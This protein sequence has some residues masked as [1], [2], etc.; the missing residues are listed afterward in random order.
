MGPVLKSVGI[1]SPTKQTLVA[2]GL[3]ISNLC[4]PVAGAKLVERLGGR[5]LWLTPTGPLLYRYNRALVRFVKTNSA[6]AVYD[7]A[8][9]PLNMAYTG[10][11]LPYSHRPKGMAIWQAVIGVSLCVNTWVNPV[12]LALMTASAALLQGHLSTSTLN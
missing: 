5:P 1:E 4:F 3:A 2:G 7:I 10:E 11:I 9:T 8:W 6:A 12:A